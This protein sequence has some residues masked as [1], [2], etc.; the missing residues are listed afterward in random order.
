M[1]TLMKTLWGLSPLISLLGAVQAGAE[2]VGV[3]CRIW[4]S[5]PNDSLT[6]T[7]RTDDLYQRVRMLIELGSAGYVVLPGGTGTLLELAMAWE[8]SV[9]GSLPGR[10]VVCLGEFWQPL[11]ERVVPKKP[12]AGPCL[13][14]LA[15]P[16]ELSRHF[17]PRR[18]QG[19]PDPA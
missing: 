19:P 6:R 3:T 8:L 9:Q 17:P 4:R 14:F 1:K 2:V 12:S 13:H 16:E 15:T 7:V 5:A 10:P 11:F 18:L